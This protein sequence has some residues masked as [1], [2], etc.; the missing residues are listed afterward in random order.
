[1]VQATRDHFVPA[2]DT[3]V[4][5]S[6]SSELRPVSLWWYLE[7]RPMFNFSHVVVLQ[8]VE[9]ATWTLLMEVPSLR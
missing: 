3:S 8:W 4:S 5:A 1:M 9:G 6:M 7:I 2:T